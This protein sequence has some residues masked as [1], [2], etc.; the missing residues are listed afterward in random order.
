MGEGSAQQQQQQQ[1]PS[2]PS[3]NT[4]EEDQ[5]EDQQQDDHIELPPGA[6]PLHPEFTEGDCTMVVSLGRITRTFRFPAHLLR[7]QL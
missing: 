1:Q 4:R 7:T 5:N 6:P 2:L 3:S